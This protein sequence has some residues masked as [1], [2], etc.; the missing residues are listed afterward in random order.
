MVRNVDLKFQG[1]IEVPSPHNLER[2]EQLR[3]GWKLKVGM[4]FRSADWEAAKRETLQEITVLL[5]PTAKL[6]DSRATVDAELGNVDLFA[7]FDSGPAFTVG[8][9]HRSPVLPAIRPPSSM[10]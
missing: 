1:D 2:L 10:A 7:E 5:Y 6:A 3:S 8:R 4:P 9:T